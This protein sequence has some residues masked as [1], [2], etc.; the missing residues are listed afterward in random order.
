M[1]NSLIN[2]II[3]GYILQINN[4]C[5][6]R[7]HKFAYNFQKLIFGILL[8]NIDNIVLKLSANIIIYTFLGGGKF[9]IGNT[10]WNIQAKIYWNSQIMKI[11]LAKTLPIFNI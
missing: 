9:N 4:V 2:Q 1:I 8:W 6:E 5:I 3:N 7:P 10:C 11:I